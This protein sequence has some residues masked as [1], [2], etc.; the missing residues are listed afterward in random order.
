MCVGGLDGRERGMAQYL[1][2]AGIIVGAIIGAIVLVLA[3]NAFTRVFVY[4]P[5]DSYGVVEKVWSR[6]GAVRGGFIALG[7]EAGFQ[8][9]VR[10][11]GPH[12]FLP[13]MYRVHVRKLI[14][15]RRMAYVFA[16]DGLPLPPEQTLARTP[17]DVN[18][19]DVRNFLAKGGQRGPQRTIMREGVY[20]VN[21]AQFVVLTD[22]TTYAIDIGSDKAALDLM[23]KTIEERQGFEPV[24]IESDIEK[25]QDWI[26]VVTVHDGPSLDPGDLI[27]PVV[28]TDR[29]DELTFHDSFQRPESFIQAGGRR[30]IQE[31]VIRE[32]TY[33]INRL[34]AT[35]EIVPKKVVN[36]GMAGVV[37]S[38]TGAA[39]TDISGED[40]RHGALV[41]RGE[42]GVWA[43]PLRPGK[44]PL[45]PFAIKLIEVPTTNFVL[46]WIAGSQEEHGY[47]AGLSEIPMIT[48]DAFEPILPLSVVVHIAPENA[49]RVIQRFADVGLLIRQTIDPMVSA[50][51][52]DVAQSRTLLELI[53]QRAELQKEAKERLS[54]RFGEYDLDLQ[55]VMIGTP[56]P[57]QADTH[58]ASVLDQLRE[59]QVAEE[60]AQTFINQQKAAEK[61]RELN[62]AR[63]K[64]A[65]QEALTASAIGIE[66]A[67][68]QGLASLRKQTQEAEAIKVQAA[69]EAERTRITGEADAARVRAIGLAQAEA[70]RAQ[71][72]AYTGSGAEIQVRRDIAQ[73]FAE[74]IQNSKVPIV[75]NVALG[76]SNGAANSNMVEALLAM[77]VQKAGA[78]KEA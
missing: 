21:V 62:E 49:P 8:P 76:G 3:L 6:R 9:D 71:V 36:I 13:F 22:D 67:A 72:E 27:A 26:G 43:E 25:D 14:T 57:K 31:E 16:R 61:E 65:Q 37:V 46:K 2:S 10:R 48:R 44:Y 70:T 54:E 56:R 17:E 7:G 64:A 78:D 32:G 75:P 52:K 18:F 29:T 35:V 20:A 51:F 59:R 23:R 47:D 24:V 74:A 66:V 73:R 11:T 69:A 63:A 45:N 12:F 60:R 1:I 50:F 77:L 15:V 53:R 4:I 28:G 39:G 38:Y 34:F 33:Y 55:E 68:N 58:M 5:A 30:G 40:Y 19:E 41:A 42:R